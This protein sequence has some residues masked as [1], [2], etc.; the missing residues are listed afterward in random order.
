M[1]KDS[2]VRVF[3]V[4][5][6]DDHQA[7][8]EY[9]KSLVELYLESKTVDCSCDTFLSG[10]ELI[11][12]G[13]AISKYNL[14][15]LDYKMDGLSG[16]ET[17]KKIY[18]INPDANIAFATN[19]Y[20]LT[21]E[22]YKYRAVRYLVKQEQ[23]FT[24]DLH[25]CIDYI[26]NKKINV[27]K[28]ILELSDSKRAVEVNSIVYICSE[29]HYIRYYLYNEASDKIFN[30]R[31]CSLGLAQDELPPNFVRIHQR[32]IVN[33]NYVRKIHDKALDI[34]LTDRNIITLSISRNKLDEV[35]RRYCLLKG[36][37]K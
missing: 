13:Q 34:R 24:D 21:R 30:L 22:G 27:Q 2:N 36:E 14:I 25:E 28:I 35:N 1:G 8:L 15:I 33:M 20:D 31:R 16:F 12:I 17:A 37:F 23:T 4:A 18:D 11:S 19:F 6:C 32:Y 5:L 3:R 26:I 7:F 9:E 10:N 29:K